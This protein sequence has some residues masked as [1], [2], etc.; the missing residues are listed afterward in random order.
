MCFLNTPEV[1]VLRQLALCL[2][3]MLGAYLY[4]VAFEDTPAAHKR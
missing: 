4:S 2:Q 3:V 1:F